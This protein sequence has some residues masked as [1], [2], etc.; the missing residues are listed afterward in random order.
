MDRTNRKNLPPANLA[1]RHFVKQTAAGAVAATLFGQSLAAQAGSTPPAAAKSGNQVGLQLYTLRDLMAQSVPDT[2]KLVA[3]VGYQQLEFAG[4][5]NQQPKALRRLLDDEGLSAPSCH[6]PLDQLTQQLGQVIDQALVLGHRFIVLP[7][8]TEEQRGTD[9][10]VYQQLA[11]QLNQIGERCQ[12]AGLQLAYHNHDFEF[13]SRNGKLPY[14]VL[15]TETD[16]SLVKMELDL[17]WVVKAGLD[18]LAIFAK[19][20]G[21]FPLWH[22]KDMDQQ[23]NF[24]DVGLGTIDFAAIFAKAS[25]AGMQHAFVERDQTDNKIN[26]IR[27]GFAATSRY[28][29]G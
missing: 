21:R 10:S 9:I 5:F 17:Y 29:R 13:Q 11:A 8:L 15:L 23:G 25:V 27:Q 26:T 4:Y 22:V 19:N 3:G 28:Q 14:D 20:P 16:A 1:R 7:Y 6:V 2:L 12:Q 18:P 24:A